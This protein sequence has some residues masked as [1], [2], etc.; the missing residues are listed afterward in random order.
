MTL[1]LSSQISENFHISQNLKKN[2]CGSILEGNLLLLQ[3]LKLQE[4]HRVSQT[5]FSTEKE[6]SQTTFQRKMS[7]KISTNSTSV[8]SK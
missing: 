8:I 4:K 7:V 6:F 5:I 2:P 1:L 3:I